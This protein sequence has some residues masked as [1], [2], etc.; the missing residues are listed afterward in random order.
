MS[1]NV[2]RL[3][4]RPDMTLVVS[5][6][7]LI[8]YKGVKLLARL[9]QKWVLTD[10]KHNTYKLLAAKANLH[11]KT[12]VRIMERVTVSPRLT[13]VIMLFKALGFSAV[14]FEE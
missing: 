5:L 13:T 12:V 4:S 7:D 11:P 8:G 14:R 10:K 9:I 3:H 1:N 6:D 2:V